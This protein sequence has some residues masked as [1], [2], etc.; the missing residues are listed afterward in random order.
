MDI[1]TAFAHSDGKGFDLELQSMPLSAAQLVAR[2]RAERRLADG[3]I[4]Q[5]TAPKHRYSR[6]ASSP[7]KSPGVTLAC[8]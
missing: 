1:G 3:S 8:L 7:V 4:V 2:I 5:V 6:K